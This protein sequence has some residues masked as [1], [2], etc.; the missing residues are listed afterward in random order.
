[1]NFRVYIGFTLIYTRTFQLS[2]PSQSSRWPSCSTSRTGLT[3][4]WTASRMSARPCPISRRQGNRTKSRG[5]TRIFLTTTS[6]SW[7]SLSTG[8]TSRQASTCRATTRAANGVDK[9]KLFCL[10]VFL[11]FKIWVFSKFGKSS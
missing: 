1:M 3:G 8:P 5:S 9:F 2:G 4:P 7:S 6:V 10:S 11:F